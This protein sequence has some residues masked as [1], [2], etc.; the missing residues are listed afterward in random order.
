MELTWTLVKE[1]RC[2]LT[3]R[4]TR[5]F[6]LRG[7]DDP[8]GVRAVHGRRCSRDLECHREPGLYCR[9]AFNGPLRDPLEGLWD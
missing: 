9:W 2:P 5:L 1:I 3:D 7:P 6:E 8:A 4:P